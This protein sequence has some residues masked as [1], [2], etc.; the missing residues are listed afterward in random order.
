MRVLQAGFRDSIEAS[1]SSEIFVIFATITHPALEDAIRVN[2]D[3][4]GVD[5]LYQGNT[6]FG[7]GFSISLLTDD[8]QPPQA[9]IAIANV[10]KAIGAAVL[11]LDT[12]PRLK[13]ELFA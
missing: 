12:A 2:S 3:A 4:P 9:K 6:Y 10:E 7:F 1:A 5:Y 8:E 13:L 11:L